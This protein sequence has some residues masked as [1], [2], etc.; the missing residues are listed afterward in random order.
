MDNCV[1]DN[2]NHHLPIVLFLVI[3]RKMFG[4]LQQRLMVVGHTH[5][6]ILY[7]FPKN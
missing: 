6:E 3:T 7:I 2:K 4:K 1:K 5:K